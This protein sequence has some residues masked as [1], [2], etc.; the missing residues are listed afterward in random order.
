MSS[1]KDGASK[2]NDDICEVNDMLQ[3]MSTAGSADNVSVCANCGKEGSSD[4]INNMCNKCKQV[5]YCNAACKKKHRSK[6]KKDC[7]EYVRLAAEHAAEKHDEELFKQPQN[8]DDCPICFL[9]MPTLDTGSRY[10]DCCGKFVCSGCVHA[11]VYDDQGNAVAGKKCPFCRVPLPKSDEEVAER[12]MKRVEVNDAGAMLSLGMYHRDGRYGF[13]KDYEK[14]LELWHRAAELGDAKAY[15]SIGYLYEQGEGVEVDKKIA[16]HFY[17]LA[18]IRGDINARHNLGYIEAT[19]GNFDRALKH[20][21]IAAIGG[22]STSLKDIQIMYSNG[23]A[24]KE[25]YTEALHSYQEYLGE[26]KSAQRD[27]AAAANEE[28]RYY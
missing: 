18:A 22:Y 7:E 11:P 13:P 1:C 8:E 15:C 9:L 4:K 6:H 26:I 5:K 19:A 28:F 17:E 20:W 24:T 21:K 25:D 12:I 10:Y 27:K 23:A 16:V 2:S 3:K 14:A